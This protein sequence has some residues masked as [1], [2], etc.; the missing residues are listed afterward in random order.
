MSAFVVNLQ[1]WD[2]GE[3]AD[4]R[5]RRI[6]LA[7]ALPALLLALIMPFL[8]FDNTQSGGG[9]AD[10]DRYVSLLQDVAEVAEQV[11]EP[12]P[13]PEPQPEPE[14]PVEKPQPTRAPPR[15]E[16][17]I[18]P[19]PSQAQAIDRAREK[20][21]NT[22]VLAMKDQLAAL[23][24]NTL[25]GFDQVRPLSTDTIAAAAG[26]GARGGGSLD[27]A[28]AASSDSGGI[29]ATGTAEQR[30]QDSGTGLGQRKT[31]QVQKPQGL[32]ANRNKPGQDGNS[33]KAARTLEE[34]QLVFDRNKGAITSIYNRAARENP[35]LGAGKIVISLTIA[36]NGAVTR[37]TLV[38]SS[39]NNADL[40]RK[41]IQRVMMM[42]FGA[43]NVPAFTYP[44]YP[45]TF[46]PS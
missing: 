5:F 14:K 29:G 7:L 19:Q 12:A 30:R 38:S 35:N 46:L 44:N 13:A 10:D 41:I 28:R 26:T 45:I 23:R 39:F 18:K 32:G 33:P 2:L 8:R 40:E 43:K 21:Q 25:S 24:N 16:P 27:I 17:V 36:P 1:G 6:M 22:G 9:D 4:R 20:A 11:E 3:A 15:P 42:N 31:T 34:I 37:C